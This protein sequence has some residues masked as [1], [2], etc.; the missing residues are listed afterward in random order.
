MTL[1]DVVFHTVVPTQR[2]AG[3][4]APIS[5]PATS[6]DPLIFGPAVRGIPACALDPVSE[7]NV[8]CV[9]ADK[10]DPRAQ[11][12][13]VVVFRIRMLIFLPGMS[14]IEKL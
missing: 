13:M 6:G 12:H 14:M 8:K 7:V 1:V 5:S 2:P 9:C 11:R 10:T 3:V 4:N